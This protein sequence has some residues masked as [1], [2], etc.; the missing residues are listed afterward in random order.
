MGKTM[1]ETTF[2]KSYLLRLRGDFSYRLRMLHISRLIRLRH[3]A[4]IDL[5]PRVIVR[6]QV[7]GRILT[8]IARKNLEQ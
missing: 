8:N 2:T 1:M 7:S 3:M 5:Q 4:V 6:S